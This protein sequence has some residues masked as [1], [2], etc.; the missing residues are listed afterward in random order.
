MYVLKKLFNVFFG[1]SKCSITSRLQLYNVSHGIL[2]FPSG[3]FNFNF[4]LISS[5]HTFFVRPEVFSGGH[6]STFDV[7]FSNISKKFNSC[8]FALP[9]FELLKLT[10][11]FLFLLF[12]VASPPR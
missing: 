3:N 6:L 1:F 10:S 4:L 5:I 11:W 7:H 12:F 9:Y 8:F 2:S